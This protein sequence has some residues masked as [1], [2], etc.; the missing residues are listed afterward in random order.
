MTKH[1]EL[2]KKRISNSAKG[3]VFSEESREKMSKSR[4][5][6]K[7]SEKTKLKMSLSSK[8]I[9]GG[10][11]QGAGRKPIPVTVMGKRYDS[12]KEAMG[13]LDMSYWQVR[14]QAILLHDD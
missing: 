6:L 12:I 11:R 1:S 5:G 14:K 2:T 4:K 7:L 8:G 3:R 13:V 9:K 10:K